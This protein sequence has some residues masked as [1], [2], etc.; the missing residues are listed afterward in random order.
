M[1]V[2]LP[3]FLM[4]T[5]KDKEPTPGL[6]VVDRADYVLSTLGK[7]AVCGVCLGS[8]F[9]SYC[10][11]K[12]AEDTLRLQFRAMQEMQHRRLQKQMEKRKEKELSFQSRVDDQKEPVEISDGLSVLQA[13]EQNSKTSFEQR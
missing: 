10:K 9:F 1:R 5:C 3:S 6:G 11:G 12:M 8:G 2:G 4:D 13:G 7:G